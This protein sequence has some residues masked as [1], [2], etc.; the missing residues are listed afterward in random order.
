M[1]PRSKNLLRLLYDCDMIP[2]WFS[3]LRYMTF[4]LMIPM[5]DTHE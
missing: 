5:E 1:N 2:M 4:N 3:F